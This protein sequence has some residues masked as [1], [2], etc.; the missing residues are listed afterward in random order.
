M[1]KNNSIKTKKM[2]FK[3]K[4]IISF[5]SFFV[6]LIF[7]GLMLLYGPWDG[8]RNL[9]ITTAMTTMNHKYL[10]TWFYSEETIN[11]VL[12]NY[13]IDYYRE[14]II[15]RLNPMRENIIAV[16]AI[17]KENNFLFFFNKLLKTWLLNA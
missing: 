3:R 15:R 9:L 4:I 12:E 13:G 5:S 16:S 2:S 10:A 17:D 14:D 11:K 1:K 6:V 7:I 8:F